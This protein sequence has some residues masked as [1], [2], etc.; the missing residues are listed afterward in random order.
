[1]PPVSSTLWA[2]CSVSAAQEIRPRLSRSHWTAAPVIVGL[3]RYVQKAH[4]VRATL[5]SICYQTRDVLE[6]MEQDSGVTLK[7]LKVDGGAVSNDFLMQL[8]ADILGVDVIRPTVSET[9]ALG[10]AYMAGLATGLWESLEDLR[11]NWGIDRAFEPRWSAD[12]RRDGYR[13]WAKAVDRARGWV[14]KA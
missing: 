12:R 3:T 9:T 11:L 8:Q 4:I 7:A 13:G 5:E 6:A 10:S 2:I 1:M 14:D